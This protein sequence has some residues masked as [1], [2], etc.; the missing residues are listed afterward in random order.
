MHLGHGVKACKATRCWLIYAAA[1]FHPPDCAW[2]MVFPIEVGPVAV[3][4]PPSA[5]V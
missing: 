5:L 4:I 1:E 3:L 2:T